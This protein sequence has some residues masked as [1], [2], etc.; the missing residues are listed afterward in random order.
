M[1]TRTA[2]TIPT[3]IAWVQAFASF[4]AVEL[5][6]ERTAE[7]MADL[8]LFVR[9]TMRCGSEGW[10]LYDTEFRQQ[11]AA[12]PSLVLSTLNPEIHSSTFLYGAN[13]KKCLHCV[14]SDADYLTSQCAKRTAKDR[15]ASWRA[16]D[17]KN[18]GSTGKTST[19]PLV[20]LRRKRLILSAMRLQAQLRAL[21]KKTLSARMQP[22]AGAGAPRHRPSRWSPAQPYGNSKDNGSVRSRS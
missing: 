11:A 14:N 4:A 8:P 21:R 16:T 20:K 9:E 17:S 10:R 19:L 22:G 2:L 5:R 18:A 1:V 3:I 6:P 15:Q 13:P 7:L 12:D